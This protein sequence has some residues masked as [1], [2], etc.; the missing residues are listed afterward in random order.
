M[1]CP[2]R[3]TLSPTG[4]TVGRYFPPLPW[5]V[6]RIPKP[7]VPN[8]SVSVL[9]GFHRPFVSDTT[10]RDRNHRRGP[11]LIM[12]PCPDIVCRPRAYTSPQS[13]SAHRVFTL[14]LILETRIATVGSRLPNH[15]VPC[16]SAVSG[17]PPLRP[18][19]CH[20]QCP[21]TTCLEGRSLFS[22]LLKPSTWW[23]V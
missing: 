3:T 16:L 8:S 18:F 7:V 22:T 10:P 23:K 2:S 17:F 1:S 20:R 12:C 19:V 5:S 9:D 11:S 21:L 4:T 6:V 14:T 15:N 13:R